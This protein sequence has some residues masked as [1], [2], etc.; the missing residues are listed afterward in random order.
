MIGLGPHQAGGRNRTRFQDSGFWVHVLFI[1][2]VFLMVTMT[3]RA[4][5]DGPGQLGSKT[6]QLFPG[7]K[8]KGKDPHLGNRELCVFYSEHELWVLSST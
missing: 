1:V 2:L 8:S 7:V 6:S 3:S 5:W 4:C